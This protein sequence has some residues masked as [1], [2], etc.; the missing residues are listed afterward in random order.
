MINGKITMKGGMIGA[1]IGTIL[2]KVAE[3]TVDLTG[4]ALKTGAKL[5][6]EGLEKGRVALSKG[7]DAAGN[8]IS[9]E[10]LKKHETE[11][12]KRRLAKAEER[13]AL[14]RKKL[15]LQSEAKISTPEA[16][17]NAVPVNTLQTTSQQ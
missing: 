5:S 15:G 3:T 1:T 10:G 7:L 17:A 8:R 16:A 4:K 6:R 13:E 14:Y 11:V 9:D 12:N 2:G